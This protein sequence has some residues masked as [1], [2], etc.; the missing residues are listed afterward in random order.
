M[1]I[2]AVCD[3]TGLSRKTIRFYEARGLISP[4]K[5]TVKGRELREYGEEDIQRL[6]R[7]ATLRR[8][9]FTVEEIRIM[10]ENPGEVP[11]IFSQYRSWLRQQEAE[12]KK[13]LTAAEQIKPESLKDW[14]TL[15]DQMERTAGNLPLPEHDIRPRFR[16]LDEIEEI[17]RTTAVKGAMEIN[18][19]TILAFSAMGKKK[20]LDDVREDIRTDVASGPVPEKTGGP[21]FLGWIKGIAIVA[22]CFFSLATIS[23]LGF[24]IGSEDFLISAGITA[25]IALMILGIT[26]LQRRWR[27]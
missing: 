8:A 26:L 5:E 11:E 16:Y 25:A 14:E 7:I 12:L 3:A 18:D 6:I 1:K 9:R 20:L 27:K 4:H 2:K 22:L 19:K 21:R 23:S 24:G 15:T 17:R 10:Q 13:L